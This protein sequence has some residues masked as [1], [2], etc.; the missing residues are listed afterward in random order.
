MREYRWSEGVYV[1]DGHLWCLLL[2]IATLP[3]ED[4][5]ERVVLQPPRW[6]SVRG[7]HDVPELECKIY[8]VP[9]ANI[10]IAIGENANGYWD[11]VFV[12]LISYEAEF[13]K[14]FP[15]SKLVDEEN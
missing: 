10:Y 6:T 11:A 7:I 3:R 14:R 15:N 13:H 9:D 4:I 2:D 8:F 1:K 5:G 12:D